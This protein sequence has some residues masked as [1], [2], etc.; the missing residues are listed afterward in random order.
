MTIVTLLGF[1][2]MAA[3]WI[4]G[5]IMSKRENRRLDTIKDELSRLVYDENNELVT[6]DTILQKYNEESSKIFGVFGSHGVR[7]QLNVFAMG[8]FVADLI[9]K[10][11]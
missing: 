7:L 2:F 11:I 4:I 1:F 8:L 10:F 3:G 9:Y 5:A 6:M